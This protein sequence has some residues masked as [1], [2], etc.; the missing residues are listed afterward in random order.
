MQ[1]NVS[2]TIGGD[3]GLDFQLQVASTTTTV[4]VHGEASAELI[5]PSASVVQT[6]VDNC[7]GVQHARGGFRNIAECVQLPEIGTGLQRVFPEWRSRRRRANDSGWRRCFR[8][9]VWVWRDRAL[10]GRC[11]S[12]VSLCRNF[13]L[14]GAMRMR[15]L[16][17]LPQGRFRTLSNRAPI[18][19]TE[20]H[21][22]TTGTRLY[23]AKNFFEPTRGD[24]P[25]KRI[26][27]RSWRSHQAR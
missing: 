13:R 12:P 24:G 18:N 17:G 19:S 27:L 8:S 21:L 25:A 6:T 9:W 22:N 14:L 15:T 5:T 26:R 7:S 16:G 3:V 11:P 10:G 4:E 20:A 2:V 1:Q 23:D